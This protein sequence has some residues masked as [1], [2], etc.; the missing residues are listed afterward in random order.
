MQLGSVILGS[1]AVQ[2]P[3]KVEIT[4]STLGHHESSPNSDEFWEVGSGE[5]F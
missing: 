2:V 5:E 3:S 1:L 4:L